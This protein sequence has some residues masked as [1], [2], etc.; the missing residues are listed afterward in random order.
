MGEI[1]KL[2]R[3]LRGYGECQHKICEVDITL[4][5]L[6]CKSCGERVNPIWYLDM[7]AKHESTLNEVIRQK[8]L[9]IENL[10]ERKRCK[11]THC[12]KITKIVR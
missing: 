5:E 4:N 1:I 11:C 10:E 3:H 6:T 9:L 2:E 8:K 12:G 7:L